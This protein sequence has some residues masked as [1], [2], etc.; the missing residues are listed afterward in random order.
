M[1]RGQ[2]ALLIGASGFIGR[3][4]VY[5]LAENG[6]EVH[7]LDVHDAQSFD[8]LKDHH[9][10]SVTDRQRLDE[11]FSRLRPELVISLAAHA[12][13]GSG[14][15]ISAE[16]DCDAAFAVNVDGLR[17]TIAA[18]RLCEVSR[19]VWASS[20]TV[21]GPAAR[22]DGDMVDEDAP[23]FPVTNYGL[24][25]SLAE[26]IG[27][28]AHRRFG[29]EVVALRPTLVLGP[30][31][32]YRGLLDPLKRLFEACAKREAAVKI[33]WGQHR[34]DIVH[35][36]D[37]AAAFAAVALARA[38][39]RDLYHVNGGPTDIGEIAAAARK[40]CPGLK[41][42]ITEET[43]AVVYPLVSGRRIAE[44]VGFTPSCLPH[45][46]IRDCI[47]EVTREGELPCLTSSN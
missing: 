17:N 16:R 13:G 5:A 12:S 6:L 45:Q 14:P 38:P 19:L 2:R 7:G 46:I 28:Y 11:V 43:P 4:V 35:V 44:D 26:E 24:T 34:F 22:H 8:V 29:H 18:C 37:A 10:G 40:I 23:R 21:L 27:A 33:G 42:E 9:R 15:G 30:G 36:L 20:T 39:L 41:V 25:K 32:P 1:S 31:L 3:H 47:T